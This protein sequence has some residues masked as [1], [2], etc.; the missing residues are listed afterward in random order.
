MAGFEYRS[1]QTFRGIPIIHVAFGHW[2]RGRYRA[3]RAGGIIAIGDTAAGVV[4]SL[5]AAPWASQ[6]M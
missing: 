5:R 4:L 3:A 2:E 1:A 6:A